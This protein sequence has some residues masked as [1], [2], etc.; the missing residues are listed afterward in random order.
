MTGV[1]I[2]KGD[3]CRRGERHV[4]MEAETEVLQLEVRKAKDC[5]RNCRIQEEAWKDSSLQ[6]SQGDGPA[7]TLT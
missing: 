5:Q 3:R 4:M 7:Y 2:S 1:L 6:I